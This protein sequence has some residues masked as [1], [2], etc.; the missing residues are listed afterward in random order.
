MRRILR[1]VLAAVFLVGQG[2][3]AF[4]HHDASTHRVRGA[5]VKKR[6]PLGDACR[7]CEFQAQARTSAPA[8]VAL[9]VSSRVVA[10]LPEPPAPAPRGAMIARARDRAPPAA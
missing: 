9:V 7:E 10:V 3:L 5:A 8:A 6:L 1:V 4:H 2:A